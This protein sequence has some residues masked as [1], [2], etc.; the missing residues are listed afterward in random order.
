M[1]P[2]VE[3]LEVVP[4]DGD[5]E[6]FSV[7]AIDRPAAGET[8]E[9]TYSLDVRGRVAGRDAAVDA[10]ELW[11]RESLVARIA[12]PV[13]RVAGKAEDGPADG[14]F[15][16]TIG[17]LAL[18]PQFELSVRAELAGGERVRVATIRGRRAR[19]QTRFEPRMQPLML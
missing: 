19:L 6:R 1:P 7:R 15:Y 9:L 5:A 8:N 2:L 17:S 10:V 14:R 3:I 16:A 13:P 4:D 12:L 11:A 18:P